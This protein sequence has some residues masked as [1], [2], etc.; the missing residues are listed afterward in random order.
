MPILKKQRP[1]AFGASLLVL[2]LA[3][4]GP[5]FAQFCADPI[6]PPCCPSPCPVFDPARVPKLLA[7]FTSLQ[8]AV[9]A[10]SQ[11]VQSMTQLGKTIGNTATTA[12]LVTK[13]LSA[14]PSSISSEVTAAQS[15][16]SANPVIALSSLKQT[17]FEPG[18]TR[19]TS[20][21]QLTARSTNRVIAAQQEQVGALATSLMKSKSLPS[22]SSVQSQLAIAA[23]GSDQL[24]AD[25]AANSTARL[26]LYQDMGGLHQLAAAWL[27]QHAAGSAVKHP[28]TTGGIV[29]PPAAAN[30]GANS[31]GVS[32]GQTVQS[33]VDQ[34]VS[35]HDSR[36]SA[37]ALLST[38]P[39]LQQTITSSTLASQ[40]ANAA[41][42]SLRESLSAL[43][44]ASGATLS[45]IEKALQTADSSGWLDSGKDAQAQQ[46]AA[47]MFMA[48]AASGMVDADGAAAGQQ[49][50]QAM[51]AWLDANKQS[52]YWAQLA[53]SAQ[54]AIAN[55]DSRLGSL[56]DRAG[57]DVTGTSAAA[58]ETALL[59]RLKQDPSAS[60]W[61]GLIV[62]V[63]QD[64][65]AQSVLKLAVTR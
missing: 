17:M 42:G 60:Q 19:Q 47:R 34:L 23:S 38:Y 37:Q 8:Q 31:Q 57:L 28:N 11:I 15:G 65:G 6:V 16:L 18:D 56:S 53:Q 40:F 24:H 12:T 52:Q 32:T 14:F 26:A 39:A 54:N 5:A 55:L 29:P 13:Q 59:N 41:E 20:A 50:V 35:L 49:A 33:T 10:D 64:L 9:T 43:G 22:V 51:T 7:D 1:A 25:L 62:A 21:T 45:D 30:S 44:M 3:V 63:S 58:V 2:A 48:L 46:A 61:Q 4:G 27:S 36:V